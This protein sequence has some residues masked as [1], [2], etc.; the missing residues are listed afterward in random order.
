MFVSDGL[1]GLRADAERSTTLPH[2]LE[3]HGFHAGEYHSGSGHLAQALTEKRIN[4]VAY[5]AFLS[6]KGTY[7]Q[8]L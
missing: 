7:N 4:T 2:N 5:E 6:E 3:G 1:A 8:K